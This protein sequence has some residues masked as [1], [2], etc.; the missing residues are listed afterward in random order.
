MQKSVPRPHRAAQRLHHQRQYAC[1]AGGQHIRQQLIPQHGR[2]GGGDSGPLHSPA[3]ARGA[4]LLCM[5]HIGDAQLVG[6]G[7][8]LLEFLFLA[9]ELGAEQK[10]ALEKRLLETTGYVQFE[11]HYDVDAS[12]L[13]GMVIR[14]GDRVVDSS[15][16]TRLYELKKELSA[17]QLA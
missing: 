12:L 8:F 17:L 1:P 4:G 5:T 7:D 9:V 6:I 16:K 13:G 14:I 11:M 15:I 10:A 2:L 3:E